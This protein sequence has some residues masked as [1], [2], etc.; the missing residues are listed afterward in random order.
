MKFLDKI[1]LWLKLV[2]SDLNIILMAHRVLESFATKP[3]F[4]I[5]FSFQPHSMHHIMFTVR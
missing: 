3:A 1:T 4:S 2:N 5:K